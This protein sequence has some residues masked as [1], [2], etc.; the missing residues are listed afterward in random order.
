M[1]YCQSL[2]AKIGVNLLF[3]GG[4]CKGNLFGLLLLLVLVVP[5]WFMVLISGPLDLVCIVDI[6]DQ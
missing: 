5:W 3:C 4:K 6:R 1:S 2:C